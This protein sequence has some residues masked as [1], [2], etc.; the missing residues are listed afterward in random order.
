MEIHPIAL[1]FYSLFSILTTSKA[2]D[3]I[4]KT[5]FIT[6]DSNT[7]IVS[8]SESFEMGFFKPGNSN[9]RYLGIWYK[10]ISTGTVVWVANRENPLP[11]SSGVLKLIDPGILVLLNS[12][13]NTVWSTNTSR[14]S[15]NPVARLLD[16]G[17]LIIQDPNDHNPENFLWQSF[18]YPCDTLLPGMKLGRNSVTGRE[19]NMSSWKSKDDPGRGDYTY[20]L[21][22]RGY[23]QIFIS[24]GSVEQFRTGPWNGL[25]FSGTG[26]REN[27]IYS[28]RTYFERD[29]VS[30]SYDSLNSSLVSR[31][32]LNSNGV[33][34]LWRWSDRNR[35]WLLDLNSPSDNCDSYRM[36]GSYGSCDV[37]KPLF[38]GCLSKFVPKN[39]ISWAM[40]DWSEGC[41]RRTPLDCK[42]GDGFVKYS[43]M[44]LPDTRSSWFNRTMTIGECSEVCLKNC[45]CV[46]YTSLNISRGGSG[47]LLWFDDLVDLRV[48]SESG[49]D[50]YIRM[51]SSESDLTVQ[52]AGHSNHK[53]RDIIVLT[54]ILFIGMLLLGLCIMLYVRKRKK[55]NLQLH[56]EGN[57]AH[58]SKQSYT[59]QIEKEDLELPLFDFA[60]IANSTNQFSIDNKLGEGGFGPVFK[61]YELTWMK[62]WADESRKTLLD[63]PMRFHI[64]IGIARGLLYLHQD[65]RLRIIHRDLKASNILLD[66]EM[67]PKISDFGM[68]RIFGGNEIEGN[69]EKVVGTYGYMSPEYVVNGLFSIKSDVFSFGVLVLEIVSGKRNRGFFHP[70]H[71]LNLLGHAWRLYKE[72]RSMQLIDEAARDKCC[73]SEALRSIHVGLLCVQ[74]HPKDRPTMSSVVLMLGSEDALPLPKQPGFFTERNLPEAVSSSS[75]TAPSSVN[76]YT[77]TIIDPR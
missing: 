55:K 31:L 11:N 2:L 21:D 35:D 7:T 19:W 38:C 43:G 69:T 10:K 34:Q 9:N 27:P 4:T 47:C 64:I 30:Y 28:I 33:V 53:K 51:A 62:I 3:T 54:L 72:D 70:D 41:V 42:N 40:T 32:I 8:P 74:Q 16:S 52:Q 67:N 25:Q 36:C 61:A 23:P 29:E 59:N 60:T 5:Q 48:I 17:N 65:S 50:I 26:L 77:I 66:I 18:D 22:P 44:K 12:T 71:H 20:W 73:L 37:N 45:S 6:V 68:A 15:H 1:F 24:N 76:D 14:S 56:T 63:W 49:Q 58:N 39:S 13:N 46:A 75:K 57:L